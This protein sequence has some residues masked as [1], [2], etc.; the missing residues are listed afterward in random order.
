MASELPFAH[1]W[2]GIVTP[3]LMGA[4]WVLSKL[5]YLTLCRSIQLLAM[6]A[7]GDAAKDLEILV[8]RHQ[9]G[10]LRRQI[11]R[12]RLEPTDRALL[13]AVSRALPSAR[14]SCFLVRPET[15]LRW[16]RRLIAGVWTYPR[17]PGRPP[18]G[19]EV[20]Q[21]IVRLARENPRWGYQRI[22]GELLRLRVHVSATAVRSVLRRHGLG[23]A[24]RRVAVTWRAFLRQQAAGIMACDFFTVDTVWLRRLYVLFFIEL[25]TRRV[26]LAGVT[27]HPDGAWVAQQARNLLLMLGNRRPRFLIR[28]R[29][30]KFTRAFDDVFRSEGTEALM[31]PVQAPNANAY[32]ERWIRTVRAECLD[33]LLI[34]GRGHLEQVLRVYV[35]HYNHHRPHRA[36]GLEPPDPLANLR[37][38]RDGQPRRVHRRDLLS[39]L[40]H[41]Y[42]RRAA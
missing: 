27:A 42:H 14:W 2:R 8:L 20:Q 22:Q 34:S 11:P 16:H 4:T 15:L 18:V 26:H 7:R 6:L 30:A 38:V 39:G 10:V 21:L 41:E 29:D 5:A 33:W 28:D 9:L 25:D 19:Q 35:A 24:P 32:A 36:L 12:P 31:T 17:G 3:P 13:A 40:L 23:P 1:S 37:V